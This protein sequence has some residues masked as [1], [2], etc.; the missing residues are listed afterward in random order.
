MEEL[1]QCRNSWKRLVPIPK[2][3]SRWIRYPRSSKS[4]KGV[5]YRRRP[6][7]IPYT[8]YPNP[9]ILWKTRT[10]CGTEI[11]AYLK[12]TFAADG[13]Q[14]CGSRRGALRSASMERLIGEDEHGRVF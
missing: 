13:A 12:R 6:I 1:G 8:P 11:W 2:R 14:T 7:R 3:P 9:P 4:T 10:F 5:R